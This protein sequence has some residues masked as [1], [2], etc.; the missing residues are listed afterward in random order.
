VTIELPKEARKELTASIR[1]YFDEQMEDEIGEL[2]AELLL[3]YCL[4]EICPTV[5]NLAI[6]D[7]QAFLQEKVGD[8]DGSCYQPEQTYWRS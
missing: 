4:R 5:Y 6:R 2:K 8:L 7:A 3:D 1:R